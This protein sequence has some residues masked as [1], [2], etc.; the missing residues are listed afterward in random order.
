MKSPTKQLGQGLI[1]TIIVLLFVGVS[2]VAMVEMQNYLIY[3]ANL[4]QQQS[5]AALLADNRMET[6]RDFDVLN[7]TSGYFAYADIVSSNTTTTIGNTTYTLTWTVTTNIG[8][9]YKLVN[10]NVTWNDTYGNT[11]SYRLVSDIA[12]TD[13]ALVA[14]YL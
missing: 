14:G 4:A 13:P 6:L 10:L 9:N 3:Q 5:N 1:E 7:T 8:P 11:Q 2:I 12:G